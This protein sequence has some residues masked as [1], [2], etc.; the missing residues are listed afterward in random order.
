MQKNI[1]TSLGKR[2]AATA[3][4]SEEKLDEDKYDIRATHCACKQLYSNS[5]ARRHLRRHNIECK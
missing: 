5:R 4:V 3:A 2:I 1:K